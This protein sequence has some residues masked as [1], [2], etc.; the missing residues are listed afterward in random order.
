MQADLLKTEERGHFPISPLMVFT[1]TE[2]PF[3]VYLKVGENFML[4][5]NEREAFTEERRRKLYDHGVDAVWVPAAHRAEYERYLE[6][7]LGAV[8]M[9][10]NL[11]VEQRS[12]IFYDAASTMVRD[13]FDDRLPPGLTE[14]FLHKALTVVKSAVVFLST[15]GS[16]RAVASLIDH[17]YKTWSHSV[18][19]FALTMALL[20]TYE[21]DEETKVQIGLG[22]LLHDIGKATISKDILQR[23]G[24]LS[25]GEWEIMKSHP[26]R[27]VALCS[28]T[29]LS[30][31]AINCILFHHERFGGG[32]YPSGL[33]GEL[34]PL[35][36]RAL[37]LADVYDALLAERP[38]AN[39]VKPFEALRIM[40]NDMRGHFDMDLFKRLV[41]VLSDAAII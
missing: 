27:G 1:E 16:L 37:T 2:L 5:T 12:Q 10:G 8:L 36:V 33:N 6:E 11:P 24:P 19:V 40:R 23:P 35:P 22:A 25:S 20:Q 39:A 9:D 30:Q 34:I 31:D 4:Y 7:Q 32:G 18:H 41:L 26:A 28:Q 14:R 17:D 3:S 21:F 13:L 29:L 15:D 38:Y